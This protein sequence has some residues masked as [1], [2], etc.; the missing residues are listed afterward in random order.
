MSHSS[1]AAMGDQQLWNQVLDGRASAFELIYLRHASAVYNHCFRRTGSWSI[2]EDLTSMVFLETWRQRAQVHLVDGNALPWLLGVANNCVRR[3]SRTLARHRRAVAR[4]P[5]DTIT[6]DPADDVVG[7]VDDQRRMA[8]VLAAM[9]RLS[10]VEREVIS[11]CV[12]SELSYAEAAVA[13]Q[14]PV[15]TVRSRLA[16]ARQR[17]RAADEALELTRRP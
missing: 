5:R 4:L 3:Q 13:M 14:V 8:S 16:R 2:A 6:P 9:R 7:R 12:W 15:G 11:L 10:R 1:A 17:L